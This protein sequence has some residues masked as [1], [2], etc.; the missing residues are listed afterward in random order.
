MMKTSSLNISISF[1][2]TIGKFITG[3]CLQTKS[4]IKSKN[5][6]LVNYLKNQ[7]Q[8][9]KLNGEIICPKKQRIYSQGVIN[10]L[11]NPKI[12]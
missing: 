9:T 3:M 12:I 10:N 7:F 2:K 6:F 4:I 8:I 1:I 5:M 11:S